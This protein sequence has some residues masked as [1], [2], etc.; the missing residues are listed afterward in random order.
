[1]LKEKNPSVYFFCF[2]KK[3]LSFNEGSVVSSVI[4]KRSIYKKSEIEYAHFVHSLNF[5]RKILCF[6]NG[7]KLFPIK[8]S[9]KE[10]KK[11]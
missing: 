11:F 10:C 8:I 4:T 2:K 7:R 5:I 9:N 1:M 3:A 6:K